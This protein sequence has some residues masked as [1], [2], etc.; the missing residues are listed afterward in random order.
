MPLFNDIAQQIPELMDPLSEN[1][2]VFG[3]DGQVAMNDETGD[4]L[5]MFM[6]EVSIDFMG[7]MPLDL[8][9][10]DWVEYS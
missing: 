4:D 6:N 7:N 9:F 10:N 5:R 2:L 1:N 3:E 8:L